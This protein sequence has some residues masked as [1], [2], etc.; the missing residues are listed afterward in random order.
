METNLLNLSGKSTS[1]V[2]YVN[3]SGV[4]FYDPKTKQLL[5]E[6]LPPNIL[7][8]LEIVDKNALALF[9]RS[10]VMRHKMNA[11]SVIVIL[12]PNIYYEKTLKS[13]GEEQESEVRLFL[14]T[15]PFDTLR[16]K[17]YIQGTTSRIVAI[18]K[19]LCESILWALE[20]V[21]IHIIAV[22]PAVLVPPLAAKPTPDGESTQY[23]LKNVAN[24]KVHT[25]TQTS[26]IGEPAEEPKLSPPRN[27]R[28]YVLGGIF[29][30]C[31]LILGFLLVSM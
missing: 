16:S 11:S 18:N 23:I 9:F 4:Q 28:V 13:S 7:K 22:I 26:E 30:V 27:I 21:G 25:I 5:A 17:I 10:L 24:L 6:K 31:I 2:L 14:D 12:S 1:T 29:T 8:D 19:N 15:V 20:Q 3:R